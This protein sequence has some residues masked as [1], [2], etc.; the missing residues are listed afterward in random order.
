MGNSLK[1]LK[2]TLENKGGSTAA[3]TSLQDL[4]TLLNNLG[5]VRSTTTVA[6]SGQDRSGVTCTGHSWTVW[7]GNLSFQG[8]ADAAANLKQL[9][10]SGKTVTASYCSG[11]IAVTC[12]CNARSDAPCPSRT[13]SYDNVGCT[14]VSR[15]SV[16]ACSCNSRSDAS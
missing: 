3:A 5:A 14:C 7:S 12:E 11:R 1:E 6:D 4:K 16:A 10:C 8:I 9:Q 13:A 2:T 15:T